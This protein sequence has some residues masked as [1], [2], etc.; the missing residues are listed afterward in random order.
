MNCDQAFDA[1]TD[2]HVRNS[3]SLIQHLDDCPRCRDMV[4]MLAPALNLFD[5][6]TFDETIEATGEYDAPSP[7][8]NVLPEKFSNECSWQTEPAFHLKPHRSPRPYPA[9]RPWM[10][11]A[12][13]RASSQKD[14]LRVAAFLMLIAVMMAAMVNVERGSRN[15]AVTITLPESC[16][17]SEATESTADNVV[18]GCVA[19]HLR[20][21]SLTELRPLQRKHAMQLVE[22]CVSCHLDMTTD[23]HL[24]ELAANGAVASTTPPVQLA[25]C[26]FG[27]RDG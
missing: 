12:D 16:Q 1:L 13:R 26:L 15:A 10:Q 21:V 17:R 23:Q 24:A 9:S 19:C 7:P 14:G 22:R 4:D 3:D 6:A 2:K 5:K 25:S 8:E 20:P 18:A 27:R 11:A